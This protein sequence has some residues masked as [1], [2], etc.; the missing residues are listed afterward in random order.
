DLS[1]E[2]KIKKFIYAASGGAS[3]GEPKENPA[4]ETTPISPLSP[5]AVAKHTAENYLGVYKYIYGL[6][7]TALRYA[8]IYGPRQDPHGEAGVV[9]IFAGNMLKNEV[10]KI[11]G[12][13]SHT[14]DYLYIK[15]VVKANLMAINK[16]TKHQ[17]FNLG[18]NV[19]TSTLE[20]FETLKKEINYKK[21]PIFKPD[22]PEV[23]DI[24]LDFSLAKKE[25]GWSPK[26]GLKEGIKKTVEWLKKEMA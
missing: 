14:R 25:L 8:N 10:C 23:V 3:Y 20:I 21:K 4:K 2:F 6:E 1:K 7:W 22:V 18:T 15:D 17:S 9:A 11:N 19:A 13:G 24:R 5:Y 12:D 26:I 16:K